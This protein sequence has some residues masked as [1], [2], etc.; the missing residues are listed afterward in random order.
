MLNNGPPGHGPGRRSSHEPAARPR[1]GTLVDHGWSSGAAP[2]LT[3]HVLGVTPSSPGFAAC[4]IRPRT[5]GL[6]WAR[7]D[8]PTP[9]GLI[10]VEWTQTK[11]R[12]TATVTTAVPC[13]IVFPARGT[14]TLDGKRLGGRPAQTKLSARTHTITV[15]R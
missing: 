6:A 13:T 4:Q 1:L 15:Q 2:V 14:V 10:H 3:Q 11:K 5:T 7:G 8:V 9:R 12:F